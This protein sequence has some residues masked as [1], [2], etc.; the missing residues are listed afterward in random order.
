MLPRFKTP[1]STCS[2]ARDIT[3]DEVI[4]QFLKKDVHCSRG[5]LLGCN[6]PAGRKGRR[7]RVRVPKRKPVTQCA[8]GLCPVDA[9]PRRHTNDGA[10]VSYNSGDLAVSARECRPGRT[11]WL[12][13]EWLHMLAVVNFQVLLWDALHSK[14]TKA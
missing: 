8:C 3:I 11:H 4:E 5:F 14:Q 2:V 7:R 9:T 10:G 6:H 13:T 12:H 1:G